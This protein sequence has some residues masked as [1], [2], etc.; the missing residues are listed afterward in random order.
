VVQHARDAARIVQVAYLHRDVEAALDQVHGLVV[1]RE[2]E[3]DIRIARGELRDA[4]QERQAPEQHGK[5]H[6]QP[7]FR[8]LPGALDRGLRILDIIQDLL[9]ARVE[10][11]TIVVQGHAARGARQQLRAE[12][13]LEAGHG[14]GDRGHGH[15]EL[16]RGRGEAAALGHANEGEHRMELVH[17]TGSERW[18]RKKRKK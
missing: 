18:T 13:L 14:L 1:E 2:V 5:R 11:A 10:I 4:R 6:A 12:V 8:R 3:D 9:A 15:A 16:G 17:G 7:A